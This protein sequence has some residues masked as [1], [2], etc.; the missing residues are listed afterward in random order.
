MNDNNISFYEK[1]QDVMVVSTCEYFVDMQFH[2]NE[3]NVG[4]DVEKWRTKMVNENV[5]LYNE[6][7]ENYS[8]LPLI[9]EGELPS[10]NESVLVQTVENIDRSL[11]R[12]QSIDLRLISEIPFW[13]IQAPNDNQLVKKVNDMRKVFK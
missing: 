11:R 9:S 2:I 3:A 8:T 7:G 1:L 6:R 10:S 12:D 5:D 4:F 13:L